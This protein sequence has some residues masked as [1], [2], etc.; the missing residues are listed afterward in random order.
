M[1][2]QLNIG[3][4]GTSW[5]AE[6][7]FLPVLQNYERAKLA[8]ICG[9]NQDRANE[10]AKKYSIVGVFDDYRKMIQGADLDAIIV[11]TP[12][13]THYEMVMVALDAG[14]HVLCEKPVA[15]NSAHALEMLN[16]A[17]QVG[18][19]HMVMYTHHWL[20]YLQ[21]TKQHLDNRLIGKVYHGYF[22]WIAD[23]ALGGNYMWR[24]DANRANGIIGDL[25]SHL[26]HLAQWYLGNVVSVTSSL[27]FHADHEALEDGITNPANDSAFFTLEFDTGAQIQFY[28]TAS[29][30]APMQ[31]SLRLQG[32]RGFINAGWNSKTDETMVS[33]QQKETDDPIVDTES[34]DYQEF[35]NSNP[36]GA[37]LFV[38]CILDD[39]DV[40]PGLKEG[41]KVQKIIDAVIE[42]HSTGRRILI[43]S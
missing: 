24:F 12:D 32:E 11:S 28:I 37:R 36:V 7:V 23:Y 6:F 41:Y 4:I 21:R 5:W 31:L 10:V 14:L 2:D 35:I 20:P 30:A 38:D 17:E 34:I 8:A 33:V 1:A 43:D 42:S 3:V 9:R 18:V 16:K 39:K 22:H 29:A 26:I 15:L 27:G 19:K 25:G 40:Y 13:D